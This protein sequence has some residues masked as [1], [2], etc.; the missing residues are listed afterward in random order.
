MTQAATPKITFTTPEPLSCKECAEALYG[1]IE[2]WLQKPECQGVKAEKPQSARVLDDSGSAYTIDIICGG[3]NLGV[4]A[5]MESS[6]LIV[7]TWQCYFTDKTHIVD[8]K[9][10]DDLLHKIM[11][12]KEL[13]DNES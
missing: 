10:Q 5:V 1:I 6:E 8:F 13:K 7:L 4:A 9:I 11:A 3:D 2:K 12:T